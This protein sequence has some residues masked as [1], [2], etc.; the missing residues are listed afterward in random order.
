MGKKI[1]VL[2]ILVLIAGVVIALALFSSKDKSLDNQGTAIF[3]DSVSA[4]S[5]FISDIAKSKFDSAYTLVANKNQTKEEFAQYMTEINKA[6][7]LDAC[8]RQVLDLDNASDGSFEVVEVI[9]PY[10]DQ[11][12]NR[13]ARFV[14]S[15]SGTENAVTIQNYDLSYL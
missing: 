7:N 14:F 3:T 15:L 2:V 6:V 12:L 13:S 10:K 11:N 8:N 9:C 1:T 4:T 5:T